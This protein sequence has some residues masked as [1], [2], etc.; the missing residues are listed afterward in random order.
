MI[1]TVSYYFSDEFWD[2]IGDPLTRHILPGSPNWLLAIIAVYFLFIYKIGPAYMANRQ[3]YNLKSII[4]VYNIVNIIVNCYLVCKAATSPSF[5]WSMFSCSKEATDDERR[6]VVNTWLALKHMDLLDTVFFVLRKN[7]RQVT[8]FHVIHHSIVPI[9]S[10][11]YAKVA[12]FKAGFLVVFL[13]SIVHIVMYA[14]YLSAAS[15]S[16]SSIWWKKYVTL[17][18]IIQFMILWVQLIVVY[19]QH[20]LPYYPNLEFYGCIMVFLA[21]SYFTYSFTVF[22]Y[23]AYV[24]P[25][26]KKS[27]D[28]NENVIKNGKAK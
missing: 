10:W 21:Y 2:K 8:P 27:I 26:E 19:P 22:Y 12:P 3:P 4:K 9:G 15:G 5:G 7:T 13:N 24:K 1:S 23:E 20:C 6:V 18:Q 14:Y 25:K 28:T 17:T 11:F 16:S